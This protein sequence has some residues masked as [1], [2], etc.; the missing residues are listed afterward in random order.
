MSGSQRLL[1]E[2][3]ATTCVIGTVVFL[4]KGKFLDVHE[5]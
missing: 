2:Q 1:K 3:I 4:G 5:R